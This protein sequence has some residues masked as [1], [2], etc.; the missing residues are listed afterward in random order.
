M[1]KLELCKQAAFHADIPL[2]TMMKAVDAITAVMGQA[3]AA[4]DNVYLRGFATF[5]CTVSKPRRARDI[6]KG[7]VVEVPAR[8]TVNMKLSPEIASDIN[9]EL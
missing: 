3:F 7:T 9:R 8:R 4:G 1:T 5:Q 2:S 6:R